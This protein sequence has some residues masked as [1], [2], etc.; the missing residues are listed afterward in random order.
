M[1]PAVAVLLVLFAV[2]AAGT[3]WQARRALAAAEPDARL[4]EAWRL[5]IVVSL[6]VPLLAAFILLA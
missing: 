5:L 6:G 3:V 1:D 4:R 2:Y